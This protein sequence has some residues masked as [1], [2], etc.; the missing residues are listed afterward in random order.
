MRL[1][2][3]ANGI[4]VWVWVLS[5]IE[6]NLQTLPLLFAAICDVARVMF[7][8]ESDALTSLIEIFDWF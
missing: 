3:W 1:I 5:V 2:S 7:L 6:V 8:V 4:C